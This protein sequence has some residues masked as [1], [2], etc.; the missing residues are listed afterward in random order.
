VLNFLK[1]VLS[2]IGLLALAAFG[3][4]LGLSAI[5]SGAKPGLFP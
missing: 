1:G 4:G 2:L 5:L 3:V